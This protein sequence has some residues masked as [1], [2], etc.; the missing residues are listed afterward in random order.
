MVAIDYTKDIPGPGMYTPSQKS[1]DMTK[2]KSIYNINLYRNERKIELHDK[3]KRDIPGP[4]TYQMPSDFGYIQRQYTVSDL[5]PQ[6]HRNQTEK[7]PKFVPTG[8]ETLKNLNSEPK[9]SLAASASIPVIPTTRLKLK[10]NAK[11][12]A[13]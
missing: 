12:E 6:H 11:E 4:G 9:P 2:F 1:S 10:A 3:T 13:K 7:Q 8:E 5:Y